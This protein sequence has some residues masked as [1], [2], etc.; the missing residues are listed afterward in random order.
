MQEDLIL[1]AKYLQSCSW[2]SKQNN[3]SDYQTNKIVYSNIT[4]FPTIINTFKELGIS[5]TLQQYGIRR[6]YNFRV[7]EEIKDMFLE[8]SRVKAHPDL[9]HKT[10]DIFIDGIPFD[11][12]GSVFPRKFTYTPDFPTSTSKKTN[13]IEWLYNNQSSEG[14]KHSANRLFVM[15]YKEG[16]DHNALK[17]RLDLARVAIKKYMD[18]FDPSNLIKIE[19]AYSDLIWIES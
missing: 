3:S 9:K 14:R 12:K 5:Q 15:Y 13:L 10:I 6:W 2:G 8:D 1:A 18:G 17:A 16:G 4:S 11:L 7:S 19:G